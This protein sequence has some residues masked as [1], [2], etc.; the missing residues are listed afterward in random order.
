MT[1][2]IFDRETSS[3]FHAD[4]LPNNSIQTVITSPTYWGKRKFS[5]DERE[6]G[7]ESLNEYIYIEKCKSVFQNS[8][9]T[10]R[11]RLSLYHH[12]R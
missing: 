8:Q 9:K 1:R 7:S 6:F 2:L 4:P 5:D 3:I 12:S 10:K 11:Y